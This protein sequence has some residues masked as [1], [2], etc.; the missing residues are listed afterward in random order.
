MKRCHVDYETYSEVDLPKAGAYRYAEHESTEITVVS[1]AIDDG[2]VVLWVPVYTSKYQREAIKKK[3]PGT[4]IHWGTTPPKDFDGVTEWRAHNAQFEYVIGNSEAGQRIGFPKTKPGDWVCTAAKAAAHGLPRKLEKA[5]KATNSKHQ[6]GAYGRPAML[7]LSRPRKPTKNN[8]DTRHT[9]DNAFDDYITLFKYNIDDVLAER[10]L[11][12]IVPDLPKREQTMYVLD[13]KM[14]DRGVYIDLQAAKDCLSL[15]EQYKA[16]LNARCRKITGFNAT[17]REKL[18]NW[19][20]E[21]G[22]NLENMRAETVRD[23]LKTERNK[24]VRKVLKIY[25]IHGMKAPSKYKRMINSVCNDGRLHGMFLYYGAGTGR[26][27]STIV[28]LQN[29]FRGI[30][31]DPDTAI[32]LYAQRD[33]KLI[34]MLYSE[35]PMQIFASTTRGMLCAPKGKILRCADYNSIEGRV[36]SW[37]AGQ[38]DKLEIYR[39]HGKVYEY[40]AATLFGLPTD[41]DFLLAMKEN[42]PEERFDGKTSE[43][44]FGFQGA[45]AALNRMAKNAGREYTED[46]ALELVRAW[47][48]ANPMIVKLWRNLENKA[49]AAVQNPGKIY[50]TNKLMFKVE[51]DW[52]YMRLPSGRRLAYYKPRLVP[53][54]YRE[55][56]SYMGVDTKTRQYKRVQTYGGRLTENAA[57]ATA[58][59]IMA[60]GWVN[61]EKHGYNIIGTVHDELY[62]ETY[63]NVGSLG[64]MCE[65]MC[66]K[67][68]WAEG[69][70]L[71]AAGWEGPRFKKD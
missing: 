12:H 58:R 55:A 45:V 9:L 6:K 62:E 10:E 71:A 69:L 8:P 31:D 48:T 60:Y 51:G 52:L 20:C 70:P 38:D 39:T 50:A 43:L 59:D 54:K 49:A 42:H 61:L 34:E 5:C 19:I 64:E 44:A 47:R 63:D 37:L 35:N 15:M 25:Q 13:M 3:I 11:D 53:G 36:T 66:A 18:F 30:L 67:A 14:N 4:H 22:V 57:Q 56:V 65:L 26:W 29:L 40:T 27:A 2:P 46:R 33:L 28:Q 17:Q 32:Q 16:K 1:Y 24:T 21:Q 23:H 68:K 41:L 7:K